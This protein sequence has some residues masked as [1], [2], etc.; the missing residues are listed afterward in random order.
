ML[1]LIA[2]SAVALDAKT[3]QQ[4]LSAKDPNVKVER[5][6]PTSI[7]QVYEV[8]LA[9]KQILYMDANGRY[10]I[11]GKLIDTK[12]W[13]SLTDERLAEITRVEFSKL[14]LE[15]AVKFGKGTRKLAVFDDPDCPYCR[16]LHPELQQLEGV[17]VYV[18]LFPLPS[19][20]KAYDKSK[21]VW[22]SKDKAKALDETMQGKEVKAPA[23]DASAVD[24]SIKLGGEI[25]INSTPTL[26]LDSGERLPGYLPAA[27]IKKRMKL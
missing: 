8:I 5:V 15:K 24:D 10:L 22:C 1:L 21:A 20:P 9:G 17:E 3:A 2:D 27:D 12:T 25:G 4:V 14:P 6:S 26:I 7:P 18:F 19:H 23:C 16:K 11:L 13:K